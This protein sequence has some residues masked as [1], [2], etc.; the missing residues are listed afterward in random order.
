MQLSISNIAWENE[1]NE[2]MYK[3]M[4]ENDYQGLEIAP[5]KLWNLPVYNNLQRASD[6]KTYLLKKYNIKISSIQSIWFARK[7]NI[8]SSLEEKAILLDYTKSAILFA[9]ACNCKNL[10][11]G[12]PK[13]RKMMS[14][15]TESQ[16]IDF[17]KE[18]GDFSF[19]H[20]TVLSLEANPKIYG[21]NFINTTYEA[22]DFVKKVNSKGFKI[23]FDFGT[24]LYNHENM[25]EMENNIHLIHHIHISEPNLEAIIEHEEHE[26]LKY[27]L[28][29]NKYTGYISIEMRDIHNIFEV[30]KIMK[31]IKNVFGE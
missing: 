10:V 7:E 13:N 30:K 9:E 18:L 16:V 26:E 1:Y 2:E 14:N 31:Y 20:N 8:F 6:Y 21:T 12:C 29:R 23:N 28:R 22:F 17:F 27:L 19:S 3:F 11:F 5:T 4:S 15:S 24:F 25:E